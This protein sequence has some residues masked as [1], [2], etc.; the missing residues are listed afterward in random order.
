M[1]SNNTS[2]TAYNT[3]RPQTGTVNEP[4]EELKLVTEAERLAALEKNAQVL[5]DAYTEIF[6]KV[7]DE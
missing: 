7:E 2:W 1:Q 6:G 5:E 4:T 3:K